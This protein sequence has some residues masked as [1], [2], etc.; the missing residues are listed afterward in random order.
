[1]IWY[2]DGVTF[3]LGLDDYLL[4]LLWND[5]DFACEN[6]LVIPFILL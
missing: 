1:M 2:F 4:C 3:A 6:K 5:V